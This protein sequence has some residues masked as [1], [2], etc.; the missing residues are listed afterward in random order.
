MT[1]APGSS[2]GP[3]LDLSGKVVGITNAGTE[4]GFN[5]AVP[6]NILKRVIPTLIEEGTYS[7]P[8]IGVSPLALTPEVV[9]QWNILNVD[10]YQT[11]LLVWSVVPD[12][13]ADQAG[14]EAAISGTQGVTAVDIILAVDGHP[15]FIGEDLTAYMEVEVSPNQVIIL[16]LWR[17]GVTTS[18]SITTTA[19]PPFQE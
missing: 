8:F 1:I 10:P 7:H 3:L 19:R 9:E 4:V 16:T 6:V 5:F 15:T 14:L 18:V 2:G 12:Y 17:S 11:G 13:P